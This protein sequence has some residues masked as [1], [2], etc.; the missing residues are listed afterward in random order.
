[1]DICVKI[2]NKISEFKYGDIAL[3]LFIAAVG[4][5]IRLIEFTNVPSGFNQDEAFAAYEAYS[6]LNFGV[7][8][9]GYTNPVYFVGKRNECACKLSCDTV[10]L[11]L[12]LLRIY[13]QTSSAYSFRM[14]TLCFL[15]HTKGAV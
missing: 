14:L 10:L 8:S 9:Y 13:I 1:M 4:I 15:S 5:F 2:K 7:D 11:A 12:R 6:L 3:I